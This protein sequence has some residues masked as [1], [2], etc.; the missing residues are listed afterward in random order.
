M[1]YDK[2]PSTDTES[3]IGSD[4]EETIRKKSRPSIDEDEDD[5]SE[6]GFKNIWRKRRKLSA[7]GQ[8][9]ITNVEQTNNNPIKMIHD[10]QQH[11]KQEYARS[12]SIDYEKPLN[13]NYLQRRPHD[14]QVPNFIPTFHDDVNMSN[15]YI[16]LLTK[17]Y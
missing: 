4:E 16:Q 13:H 6:T 1:E 15:R 17:N 5:T 9:E 3:N 10:Q 12:N 14:H 8:T 2:A 7:I 11:V